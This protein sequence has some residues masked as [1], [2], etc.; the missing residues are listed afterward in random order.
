MPTPVIGPNPGA[1]FSPEATAE[2]PEPSFGGA[3]APASSD[4]VPERNRKL[5]PVPVVAPLVH[6]SPRTVRWWIATGR[7]P[8]V[9]IGRTPFVPAEFFDRGITEA[10]D[11]E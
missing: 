2:V 1:A 6:R 5:L 4:Y 3:P 9:Y 8:V 7:L 11:G 10:L